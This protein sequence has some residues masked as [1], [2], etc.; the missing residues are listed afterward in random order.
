MPWVKRP[1]W[2]T[3]RLIFIGWVM[4]SVAPKGNVPGAAAAQFTTTLTRNN[5]GQVLTAKDP[6]WVS[7]NPTAHIATNVYDADGNLTSATDGA[8]NTAGTTYDA[9]GQ[10]IKV[11]RPDS[12]TLQN[13]YY[14]DGTLRTQT[15]GRG[16]V[17]TYTYDPLRHLASIKDPLNRTTSYVVDAVGNTKQKIDPAGSCAAPATG[18]TTFTYDAADRPSGIL[19]SDGTTPGVTYGYDNIDRRTSMSDGTG[20]STYVYDTLD[21]L[22]SHT[23]SGNT[24]GY[25]YDRNDN[26]TRITYPGSLTV[27]RTYDDANRFVS[28]TDW[29]AK[30]TR[31]T[32][33][34]NSNQTSTVYGNGVTSVD[35]FDRADQLTNINVG[36]GTKAT[37]GY[38]R[39]GNGSLTGTTATGVSQTAEALATT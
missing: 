28:V 26:L 39:N 22:T 38:T 34:P 37:F 5:Y 30:T 20:L 12:T 11:T 15:D 23:S 8:N 33:D 36:K 3:T 6:L 16:K 24:V 17:T 7:T 14:P 1:R 13:S 4:S 25:G 2:L 10:I 31:F 35:T 32:Y 9:A 18:C 27:T 19:Y 21:R 29:L